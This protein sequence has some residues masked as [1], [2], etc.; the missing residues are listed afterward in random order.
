MAEA[1]RNRA[2]AV[3][4]LDDLRVGQRFRTGT[5]ALDEGQIKAFAG[6]F[7]PQPFHLDDAEA[8]ESFFAGLAASGWHTAA[9]TMRLMVDGERRSPAASSARAGRSTG[10][11][12]RDRATS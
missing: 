11:S 4:Y 7:D 3:L 5:H 1:D 10:R 6:Q 8:R 12:P 9:I 2:N